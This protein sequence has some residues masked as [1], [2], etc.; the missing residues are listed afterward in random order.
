MS[1]SSKER[2]YSQTKGLDRGVVCS[3]AWCVWDSDATG[4]SRKET[5][6]FR[7]LPLGILGDTSGV[8]KG[9]RGEIERASDS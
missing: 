9:A 7:S 2:A 3:R 8:G 1:L 5:R 6:P 4:T